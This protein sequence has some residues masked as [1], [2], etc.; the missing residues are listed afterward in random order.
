MIELYLEVVPPLLVE[1]ICKKTGKI[2]FF[3]SVI[4]FLLDNFYNN[5][6]GVV[7]LASRGG[8]QEIPDFRGVLI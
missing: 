8:I 6:R 4:W 5:S 1:K 3:A 2:W 7:L